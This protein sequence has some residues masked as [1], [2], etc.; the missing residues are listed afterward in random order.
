MPSRPALRHA[1]RPVAA[2]LLGA[3]ALGGCNSGHESY[4]FPSSTHMPQTVTL[5]N[6]RTG[7][8]LWSQE[9]PAGSQLNLVFVRAPGVAEEQNYDEMRWSITPIGRSPGNALSTTPTS[10]SSMMRVPPPSERRLDVQVREG[11]EDRPGAVGFVAPPAQ[12]TTGAPSQAPTIVP[13][14][15]K[16]PAPK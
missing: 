2:L 15:P 14:D 16:Q 13:P 7:E 9:V 3:L 6:T 4:Q 11:P 5:S 8:R 10:R 1:F 12:P